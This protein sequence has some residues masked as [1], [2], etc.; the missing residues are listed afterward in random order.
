MELRSKWKFQL[1]SHSQSDSLR[2]E[3]SFTKSDHST[4][5][6]VHCEYA[7]SGLETKFAHQGVAS[8]ETFQHFILGLPSRLSSA[9]HVGRPLEKTIN[10]LT[11]S[12][13]QLKADG[14]FYLE[15][16]STASVA[17]DFGLLSL[18]EKVR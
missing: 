5:G 17:V 7:T 6:L 13:Q 10:W 12:E 3:R 1:F 4:F 2:C 18:V 16:S 15:T 11:I 9:F 8:L 14:R